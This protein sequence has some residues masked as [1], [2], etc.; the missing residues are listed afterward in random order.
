MKITDALKK[1]RIKKAELDSTYARIAVYEQAL[2]SNN[3][4]ILGYYT[5]QSPD[6]GMPRARRNISMVEAEYFATDT[7]SQLTRELVDEWIREEHDRIYMKR[8]EVE[9]IEAAMN[10]LTKQER[11]IVECKYF[12]LMSWRDIEISY[13]NTFKEPIIDKSLQ[14]KNGQAL[15][16]LTL[17]LMPFYA[18]FICI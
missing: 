1:Y 14:A 10:S 12:D 15:T 7:E 16:K 6:A 11:F 3:L 9:Q 18:K 4:H 5:K 8:I 2:K 17:I 13:F